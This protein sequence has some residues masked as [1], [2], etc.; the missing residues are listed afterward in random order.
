MGV[1]SQQRVSH[2]CSLVLLQPR[3]VIAVCVRA[4]G[5][6]GEQR[7]QKPDRP[8]KR[9]HELRPATHTDDRGFGNVDCSSGLFGFAKWQT[10]THLEPSSSIARLLRADCRRLGARGPSIAAAASPFREAA[11][12]ANCRHE[13]PFTCHWHLTA[14]HMFTPDILHCRA[15]SA[16]PTLAPQVGHQLSQRD[17]IRRRSS[18]GCCQLGL[19]DRQVG[20]LAVGRSSRLAC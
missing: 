18:G 3:S 6:H 12:P 9:A 15:S 14:A 4:A 17:A 2:A 8:Q 10:A 13:L 1:R 16:A 7:L 19:A 11:D 20:A 5:R